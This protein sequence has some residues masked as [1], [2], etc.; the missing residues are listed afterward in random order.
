MEWPWNLGHSAEGVSTLGTERY[1]YMIYSHF[2]EYLIL[3]CHIGVGM[4]SR[5]LPT[6][7]TADSPGIRAQNF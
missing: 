6:L 5:S 3:V 7:H 2:P 1:S 4:P